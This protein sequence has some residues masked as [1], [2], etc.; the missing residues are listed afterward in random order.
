MLTRAIA[1]K[2]AKAIDL[3]YLPTPDPNV[4]IIPQ[5]KPTNGALS[6]VGAVCP[7]GTILLTQ[8]IQ[9]TGT[10]AHKAAK[11]IGL[12]HLSTPEFIPVT[13]PANG[14]LSAVG[15]ICPHVTVIVTHPIM[16]PGAIA[17][18]AAKAIGLTHL[19]SPEFYS[20]DGTH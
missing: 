4:R 13:E 10:I 8:T 7:L 5:T 11:A 2:A 16:L 12:T 15:T 18:K 1:H 9:L 3:T 20:G 19:P 17:H 14:T 6:A